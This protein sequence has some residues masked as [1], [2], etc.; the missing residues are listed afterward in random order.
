VTAA[1]PPSRRV[2]I[3]GTT[4][5]HGALIAAAL[6]AA[7]RSNRRGPLVYE[8]NLVAAPLPVSAPSKSAT[9]A[10]PAPKAA[11]PVV[12]PKPKAPAPKVP[13]KPKASESPAVTKPA[14]TP[15]PGVA[16]ST[17]QDVVTI[18]QEGVAFPYPEYLHRI[19][20]EIYKQ[21][22]QSGF[23][24]G[25]HVA[26]AFVIS[27]DGTVPDASISIDTRSGNPRFDDRAR[28]A[29]EAASV[30]HAFGPLPTGFPSASL[31][32]LFNFTMT[33]KGPQ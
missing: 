26:I 29:I 21:W 3:A 27:R 24:N 2:G 20:N 14:N 1:L 33:P 10:P 4:I 30:T 11:A 18:H 8:V 23:R 32:I 17:G 31:P 16:P 9:P 25:L 13:V 12:K 22:D 28:A 19:E 7:S 6:F 5:A 15:L